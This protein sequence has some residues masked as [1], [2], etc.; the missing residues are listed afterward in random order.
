MAARQAHLAVWGGGEGQGGPSA[1][2]TRL[3]APRAGL[4]TPPFLSSSHTQ[5]APRDSRSGHV[6][7]SLRPELLSHSDLSAA[8][9]ILKLSRSTLV[10]AAWLAQSVEHET[11][12]L[13][14]VGS[15]PTLGVLLEGD[16]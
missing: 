9:Q 6:P 2:T 15:S 13:R 12:N 16:H 4:G 1:S 3:P 5:S 7:L 11:L 10:M 14:V 8:Q